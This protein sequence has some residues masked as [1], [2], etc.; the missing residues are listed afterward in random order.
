MRKPKKIGLALGG[1]GARGLAH[2]GVMKVLEQEK[3]T[4]DII[5]G[6]SMGSI[7][8]GAFASG[9]KIEELEE[10]AE[11]FLKSDL[12]QSSELKAMGDAESGD[13][14]R[15]SKRIQ[16]YFMTKIRLAQA[17]YRPSIL[18]IDEMQ[19][20]VN[21]F[22]PDIQIEETIIPFRAVATDLKSG[23]CVF[24]KKGSLRRSILASSAVPGALP[25]VEINGRQLSDG[26]IICTVPVQYLFEEGIQEVIA[27]AVDRDI[28]LCSELQTAVDIYVRAGEIQGF[29]LEKYSLENADIVIRPQIGNIHWTDF[30]QSKELISLGEKAAMDNLPE[31]RRLAKRIYKRGVLEGLKRSAKKLFGVKL[32]R[33]G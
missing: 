29:H 3:I 7:V 15:L 9:M 5:V 30:S 18:Q 32:S 26:G 21:F 1:G 10:K 25:P 24:L 22:I 4:P 27:I 11:L 33:S 28:A 13:E 2:I 12:Y 6:T 19:E 16:S 23:E 31:I 8:G 14:Q 17:L 20:F